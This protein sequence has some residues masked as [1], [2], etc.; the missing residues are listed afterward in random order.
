MARLE[1]HHHPSRGGACPG[2]GLLALEPEEQLATKRERLV[3][4]L[5]RYPHLDLPSPE[6]VVPAA[7]TAGYRHRLKL[8]VAVE[9]EQVRV[10]LYGPN[11]TVLD[12]PDCPVLAPEL[13]ELLAPILT[14]LRGRDG[15]HS[16]D[17]RISAATGEGTGRFPTCHGLCPHAV[18]REV[19]GT[20]GSV[21]SR[22]LTLGSRGQSPGGGVATWVTMPALTTTRPI[23]TPSTSLKNRST[24]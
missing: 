3:R 4:A 22:S 2:C 19:Q 14:W 6:A 20:R 13:R 7:F 16:I 17:L 15:V 24:S 1:C 9:G 11:H 21:Q 12:T 23:L 10:G 5:E 8:P 18:Q